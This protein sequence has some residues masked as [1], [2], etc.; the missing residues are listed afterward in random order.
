MGKLTGDINYFDEALR[1]L[2]N[3]DKYLW[4]PQKQ[5][6]YHCYYTDLERNGVAFWGRANGWIMVSLADLIEAMPENHPKRKELIQMLEKQIV[7]ASRWQNANG[8]WNQLL[9][10]SDSYDESSITAMYVY[11]I[12]KA[13]NHNWIDPCY[14]SIAKVAWRTLKNNEITP[15]GRFTNVCVGTGI[16]DDLPFYFNRPVGDNEKHGLGLIINAGIEMMILNQ[17]KK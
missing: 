9:D 6:Y 13:I 14:T 4:C 12:A 8:M 11:G 2:I 15:D 7:G 10:K 17:S 1:Q 3:I 5:L 16:S